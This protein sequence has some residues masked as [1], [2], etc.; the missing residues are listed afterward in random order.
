MNKLKYI[1]FICAAVISIGSS[2]IT[3]ISAV[4]DTGSTVT[5]QTEVNDAGT[6]YTIEYD[7]NGGEGKIAQTDPVTEGKDVKLS[8]WAL[9]RDGYSH[10]G[11]TDGVNTYERGQVIKMP[12]ENMK[13]TAVWT[14]VYMLTYEDLSKYGY[15]FPLV[16]HTVVPGTEILLP[17]YAMFNGNA[18]F[19][20]WLVNGEYYAPKTKFIMPEKDTYVCPDW[21]DPIT[22]TYSTGT[23]EGVLSLTEVSFVKY[24]GSKIELPDSSRLSRLGYKIIGW[25][26]PAIDKSYKLE[27]TYVIPD[28]DT[29]IEAVWTPIQIAIRF[30]SNGGTGTMDK[31]IQ[32][33]DTNLIFP[34]CTFSNEGSKLLA[35]EYKGRYY[36]P[37]GKFRIKIESFGE[38]PEFKAVWIDQSINAGDLDGNNSCDIVDMSLLSLH[39]LGDYTLSDEAYK[40]ADVLRDGEINLADL[41][42]YKQYIMHEDIILGLEG[43]KE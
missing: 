37:G 42:T 40:N 19:N 36:A 20:G 17:N 11:W 12:P 21:L 7:L 3:G 10:S 16:D 41:T 15:N 43:K 24:P 18:Q 29:V 26:D 34:E 6:L 39:M 25:Y 1:S 30:N 5:E 22:L 9:K 13:L 32:T 38:S 2:G 33:Y 35:W 8:V 27:Q 28:K 31:I 4:E 23:S 14:A